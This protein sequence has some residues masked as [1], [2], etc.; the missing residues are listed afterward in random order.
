LD[1][2]PSLLSL[3]VALRLSYLTITLVAA[4]APLETVQRAVGVD[5]GGGEGG[6][7]SDAGGLGGSFGGTGGGGAG[8][9]GG[10][11]GGGGSGGADGGVVIG[12]G[13]TGGRGGMG[14]GGAGGG[15]GSG[16]GGGRGGSGGSGGRDAGAAG[17]G[18]SGG[19]G[20]TGVDGGTSSGGSG[21]T[22]PDAA[23][24]PPAPT[25]LS[26][27]PG[28]REVTLTWSAVSGATSYNVKRA[29]SSGGPFNNVGAPVT[30][31]SHTDTT[32]T[33]GTTY[34]Y[35]VSASTGS[36]EGPASSTVSARP[37]AASA[38]TGQDIGVVGAAGSHSVNGNALSVTGGGADFYGTEDAFHFVFQPV[39]G[40]ATIVARVTSV[41]I[42][43][44]WAK[45]AVMMRAGLA[46]DA[47]N[48]A[49]VTTPTPSN[50]YRLQARTTTA[51]T[52]STERGGAGTNPVWLRI[53]RR[54]STFTGY[55]SSGGS[56]WTQI[57][58]SKTMSLPSTLQVGLAVTSHTT[59]ETATAMFDSVSITTP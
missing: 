56:P 58:S 34:H 39:T 26:A 50:D 59:A 33:N 21:G 54:G 48:V 9:G 15:G 6:D 13:G 45:A 42:V 17:A 41:E 30:T 2:R 47:R 11:D 12:Q 4:C 44:V 27:E 22:Q 38:W 1:P 57:G 20:G 51:G 7:G 19:R 35:R 29:T 37:V 43:Q 23:V 5:G 32:V 18:G 25:G 8:M 3:P 16:G 49:V 28:D 10:G 31:T 36:L 24:A 40:D 52:T 55:Y 46:P 14:S 53:V